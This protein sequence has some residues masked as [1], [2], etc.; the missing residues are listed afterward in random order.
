M[1]RK[2]VNTAAMNMLDAGRVWSL[3]HE[4]VEY[5]FTTIVELFLV[6]GIGGR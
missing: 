5:G 6:A 4:T 1:E 3:L 2:H